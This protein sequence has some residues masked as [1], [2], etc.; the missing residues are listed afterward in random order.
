[1]NAHMAFTRGWDSRLIEMLHKCDA[2][3]K[4]VLTG[5]SIELNLYSELGEMYR[6]IGFTKD[7]A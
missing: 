4:A 2:G 7:Y 1:M 3:E 6:T 5:N